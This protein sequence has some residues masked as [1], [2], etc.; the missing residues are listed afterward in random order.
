MPRLVQKGA[1]HNIPFDTGREYE[2][3]DH[4]YHYRG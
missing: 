2:T 1:T 3:T 4:R